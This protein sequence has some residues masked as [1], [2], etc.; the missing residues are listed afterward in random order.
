MQTIGIDREF[1]SGRRVFVTGHTGFIGGWMC[2][3]L[4]R[5]GARTV[6]YALAPP[7]G[8]SFHQATRLADAVDGHIADIRDRAKLTAAIAEFDPEI[9]VHLAAQPLVRKAHA[10]PLETIEVNVM[11]T[12]NLLEALRGA[13]SAKAAVI[14]T[15]DKVYRDDDL[16]RGYQ[17]GDILGGREPYGC[18]KACAELV[19]DAYRESYFGGTG[20]GIA[21]V[22]A[23]NVIGGG[24]WAEDRLIP[25]A[26]RAFASGR[27]LEI[28]NPGAIR[29]WQHALD[30]VRGILMLAQRL[31]NEPAAW[32]GGWNFGPANDEAWPV[33]RIA[34]AFAEHWGAEHWS[35]DAGWCSEGV[36]ANAPYEAKTLMLDAGKAVTRLG[37][38]PLWRLERALAATS[39]W[40]RAHRDGLDVGALTQHQITAFEGSN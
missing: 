13:P 20:V 7:D 29:P 38:R 35:N 4:H 18:S 21:T 17:E 28:R 12:A 16:D 40:Y 32:T 10:E 31:S 3:W 37:W 34:G 33:S 25:D 27:T 5:L 6:G 19:V 39:E 2:A 14:M 24:D 36:D 30:P 23:G 22:R 1:W 15:T 8:P 11:G 9:V 26:V